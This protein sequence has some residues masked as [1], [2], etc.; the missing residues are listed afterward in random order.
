MK[1]ERTVEFSVL[2]DCGGGLHLAVFDDEDRCIY[3]ASGGEQNLQDLADSVKALLA[4]D[5]PLRDGWELE[6]AFVGGEAQ[7]VYEDL[8]SYPYGW[9]VIGQVIAGDYRLYPSR[10]GAA[11]D[12]LLRLI[13]CAGEKVIIVVADEEYNA[14]EWWDA[15]RSDGNAPACIAQWLQQLNMTP[16]HLTPAEADEVRKW[17]E[18]LPG[19]DDGPAHAPHPLLFCED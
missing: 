11:G 13:I 12:R 19:W 10:A 3:F 15:A 7:E 4:G 16:L 14:E 1:L 5:H 8:I 17:A 6:G 2:E 9:E 18:G